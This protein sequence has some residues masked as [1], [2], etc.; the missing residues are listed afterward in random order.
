[1]DTRLKETRDRELN[2][3]A[4]FLTAKNKEGHGLAFSSTRGTTFET[5]QGRAG[6]PGVKRP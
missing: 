1:M 4:R 3:Y 5:L 6:H 2:P